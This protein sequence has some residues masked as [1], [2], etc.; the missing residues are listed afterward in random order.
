[1]RHHKKRLFANRL[2]KYNFFRN[3]PKI[4][5]K[6][7]R[8]TAFFMITTLIFDFGGVLINLDRQRCIDAFE[9]L[10]LHDIDR[11]IDNYA[12]AGIFAQLE[13]GDITTDEFHDGVRQIVGKPIDDHDI[14][15]ALNAFLLDIP[16]EKLDMLCALHQRFR[17]LLLSNTNAIHFPHSVRTQITDK[18]YQIE[19]L[20]DKCY[21]SYEIHLSKP[22]PEIFRFLLDTE[23]LDPAECL[24]FDDSARNID[25]A[26]ALGINAM[27]VPPHANADFFRKNIAKELHR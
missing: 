20:I 25:T 8:K 5:R 19:Q 18:G 10:G 4:F 12:Q 26:K 1:M 14:D 6:F 22:Q 27:L 9:Q 21:L 23:Q 15:A 16:T 11:L 7:V 2:Q 13:N 24:F 3:Q 17:I